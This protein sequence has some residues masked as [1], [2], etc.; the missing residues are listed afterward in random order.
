M[1]LAF[2]IKLTLA[3]IVGLAGPTAMA[4]IIAGLHSPAASLDGPALTEIAPGSFTY[5]DAGDHVRNGRP[6]EAP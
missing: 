1:L 2:K 4:P 5:R 6:A 3:C